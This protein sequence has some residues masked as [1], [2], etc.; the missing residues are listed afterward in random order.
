MATAA[1]IR[2]RI[3]TLE[4]QLYSGVSSISVGGESTQLVSP[5]EARRLI[6]ELNGQLSAVLGT[7]RTRP[8]AASIN[9]GA[10]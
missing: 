4:D 5:N 2:E 8:R 7:G 6:A 1:V 9:L 3:A 10:T